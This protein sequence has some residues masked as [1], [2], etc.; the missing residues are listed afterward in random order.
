MVSPKKAEIT[1]VS[2]ELT[3]TIPNFAVN[4]SFI[5]PLI[6]F[7]DSTSILPL[8]LYCGYIFVATTAVTTLIKTCE[9]R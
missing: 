6:V 7:L 4:K 8:G 1:T 5:L 2:T 9:I 3:I